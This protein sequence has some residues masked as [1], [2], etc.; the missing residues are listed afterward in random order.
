MTYS[1]WDDPITNDTEESTQP[2][3]HEHAFSQPTGRKKGAK[4]GCFKTGLIIA[5]FSLAGVLIIGLIAGGI[6]YTSL[7]DEL[8][9]DLAILNSMEG[10]DDFQSSIIYDRNGEVLYELFTEGRRTEVP[11]EDI[12]QIVIDSV[13]ATED[14]DFY[15]H[16]GFDP[17]S[18]ARVAIEWY[19]YGE[20]VSG[21]ST[22]TQQ[23]IRQIVFDYDERL[24]QTLRRKFKE[25]ALA[26]VMEQRYEK[27]EILALYLNEVY[28]GNLA[29]GIEAAANVYFDKPAVDLT[30]P[31]AAF[32]AG[33]IQSPYSYDPYTD[34]AIAKARQRQVLDLMVIHDL[35]TADE[36]DTAF[37]EPPLNVSQLANPNINLQAPHFTVEARSALMTL[38]GIDEEVLRRGGLRI[39]T[40]LDMG[41]QELAQ[42]VVSQRVAEVEE[43]ANLHNAALVA[44]HPVTGEVLA[45]VGSVDYGNER[46]DGAVNNIMALHQPGSTMKPITYA[47]ALEQGKTLADILWD[48]PMSFDTGAGQGYD[49]SPVNYDGRFHGPVRLRDALANSYNIPAV[50]LADEVSVPA[51]LEMANRLGIESLGDDPAQYG[52]S[53]TLGGGEVMPMEMATAF[54]AFANGGF[55][56]EPQMILRIENT[57]G[58]VVYEKPN[59]LGA[60]VL[61]PRVAFL[62]S[63]TLSD[64]EA[65]TPAMGATSPLLL[66]FPAA[67]KTGTTNDYRDNW[68]I[69]YTPHLV[70]AV[71]AGNTDNSQMAEGTSGL[72]G[73][74]PIWHDFMTAVYQNTQM[75]SLLEAPGL[76]ALESPFTPPDGL[77]RE[78]ICVLSALKDPQPGTARC[79]QITQEWFM[80][81]FETPQPTA[82]A[83][84]LRDSQGTPIPSLREQVERGILRLGVLPLTTETQA[85]ARAMLIQSYGTLPQGFPVPAA[86]LYCQIQADQAGGVSA[87]SIAYQLFIAAPAN[88]LHALQARNWAYVAGIPIEPGFACQD[89]FLTALTQPTPTITDMG[90]P[91]DTSYFISSPA[92][93]GEVW[94]IYPIIGTVQFDP[95]YLSYYKVEIYLDNTWRTIGETHDRSV[96][97]GTLETLHAEALPTGTYQLRLVLV[98]HDGNELPPYVITI[99][100]VRELST[101]TPTP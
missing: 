27:D 84:E 72:T 69:G 71:W 9:E 57:R 85:E 76:P 53:L 55:Q 25:I 88:A 40:T 34:F 90:V 51:L 62:I 49:Y 101:P 36:A 31:E 83:P 99:K 59:A 44:L 21:G 28:F 91:A 58:E 70:V 7:S 92:N 43:S 47:A 4:R 39:T 23:L 87:A 73:A 48:V 50:L 30:L 29:Y 95:L 65:R 63:D 2:H 45:M 77:Y 86:P 94:G 46:I 26:W 11:L 78:S 64:N 79:P 15:A 24:E 82:P 32:L 19:R 33:L 8:E 16:E 96:I 13:L 93:N 37:N 81:T 38:P 67:A 80:V 12:P 22:V 66:D 42:R 35:M 60:Q 68:T 61:D 1:E 98:K 41:M 97:N 54:A 74:A 10:V 14:D 56:L 75:R 3:P 20:F 52:L 5:L 89:T 17:R 100:V 18:I 6:L